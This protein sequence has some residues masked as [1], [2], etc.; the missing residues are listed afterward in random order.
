V[1]LRQAE[2]GGHFRLRPLEEEPLEHDAP[3]P[4]VERSGRTGNERAVE[5]ELCERRRLLG[6]DVIGE[7][8]RL[9]GVR[10]RPRRTNERRPVAQVPE[11]LALDAPGDVR[12]ELGRTVGVAPVDSADDGERRD[13]NEVLVALG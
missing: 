6:R 11:E 2:R 12:R 7:R 3:L 5:R 10:Q 4:L 1:R 9:H 8:R 13:L